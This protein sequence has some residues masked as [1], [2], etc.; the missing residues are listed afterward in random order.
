MLNRIALFCLQKQEFSRKVLNFLTLF[1]III[2]IGARNKNDKKS[3]ITKIK[4]CDKRLFIIVQ[5]LSCGVA[6]AVS[7]HWRQQL[8]RKSPP[9]LDLHPHN[10]P[11]HKRFRKYQAQAFLFAR[12]VH[13]PLMQGFGQT[14]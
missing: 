10:L 14:F 11:C 8:Q 12:L 5:P 4:V 7:G 6:Q 13:L 3:N 2:K 1:I 9:W